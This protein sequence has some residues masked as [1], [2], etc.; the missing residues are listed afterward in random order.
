M[1]FFDQLLSDFLPSSDHGD[2]DGQTAA[3]D[4][5]FAV[6]P[7][8]P[9]FGQADGSH[10]VALHTPGDEH[11]VI[12]GLVGDPGVHS[13][14]S[15]QMGMADP[16]VHLDGYRFECFTLP[17]DPGVLVDLD[18]DGFPDHT[19]WGTPVTEVHSY[20][21]SDGTVVTGHFRT[22]PDATVWNNLSMQGD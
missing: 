3:T 4:D 14:F 20:T 15:E 16:L 2:S 13:S 22:H 8:D 7:V 17:P 18:G 1:D 21:R 9:G 11:L 19:A 5:Q 6:V 10:L 12:A